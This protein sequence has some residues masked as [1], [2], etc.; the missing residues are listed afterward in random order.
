MSNNKTR[1]VYT[2]VFKREAIE[3]AHTSGK[4]VTELAASRHP[5][6]ESRAAQV[7]DPAGQSGG[8]DGISRARAL[9]ACR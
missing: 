2:R 9:E 7:L 8:R 3:L 1:Q 5:E 6:F 4:P